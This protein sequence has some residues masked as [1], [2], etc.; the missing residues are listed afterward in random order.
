MPGTEQGKIARL[1]YANLTLDMQL[2]CV[3]E[4]FL[5][6]DMPSDSVLCYIAC[7]PRA[8]PHP[9]AVVL[10]LPWIESDVV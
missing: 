3:D 4:L 1:M 5:N 10:W 9:A 6:F 8:M 2:I 7:I